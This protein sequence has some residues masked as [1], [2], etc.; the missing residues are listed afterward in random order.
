MLSAIKASCSKMFIHILW[1]LAL[2]KFNYIRPPAHTPVSRLTIPH[3]A[4]VRNK[5]EKKSGE[6]GALYSASTPDQLKKKEER[7]KL[8]S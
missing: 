6:N 1:A 7:K 3:S 2:L 5:I 8:G 4:L